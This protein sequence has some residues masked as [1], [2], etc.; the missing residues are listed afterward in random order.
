LMISRKPFSPFKH[1]SI[2]VQFW[3]WVHTSDG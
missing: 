2:A 3:N 1:A